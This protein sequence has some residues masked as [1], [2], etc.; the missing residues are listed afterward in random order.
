M[1][2]AA[3]GREPATVRRSLMTGCVF[4]RD[5]A[6]LD[7]KLAGR[8]RTLPELRERGMAAGTGEQIAVQLE[9]WAAAGVQC[10]MLQWLELDDLDG[11][12]ALA[13]AV[14]KN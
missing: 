8:G 3:A 2:T 4:G 1:H 12:R 11:L 5:R 6:E 10:I 7:R 9:A 13:A 14:L